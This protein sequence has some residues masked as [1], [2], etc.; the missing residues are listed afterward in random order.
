[1][2]YADPLTRLNAAL[3][4]RYRIERELGEGGMATVYLADDL[5]HERQ[6]ALKVLKPEL[7][8]IV[9][10]KRFL[11]EIKTTAN[12]QHP[13]ILPLYDSG[14]ADGFPFYVMPYVEDETLRERLDR[15]H[16]LPVDEAV[17]IAQNVAEALDYAHR[18][19]VI[20][21]DIKPGNVLMADGKAVVSDFGIALAVGASGGGRLTET[22]MTLGTPHYMSPEQAT[23]D[24]SAGAAA[25]VYA[26]GCVL[27]EMLVGDPPFTGNTP[28]AV[29][30]RIIIGETP[31]ATAERPTVPRNVDATIRRALEKIP[32]DRFVRAADLASALTD[33]TFQHG[34]PAAAHPPSG[35]SWTT[36][37]LAT[38]CLALSAALL[39]SWTRIDAPGPPERFVVPFNEG[40]EPT[41]RGGD[42]AIFPD[43]TALVYRAG[44]PGQ[45]Q[46][47]RLVDGHSTSL[48]GTEGTSFLG[49][50]PLSPDAGE[51]AFRSAEEIRVVSLSGGGSRTLMRGRGAS[52]GDEGYLYVT[53]DDGL[54]RIPAEGGE[55]EPVTRLAQGEVT[56]TFT[57]AVPG[58]IL[59]TV[60]R[61]DGADV[62]LVEL[63][64]FERTLLVPDAGRGQWL[65]AGY[66]VYTADGAL[67]AD[68]FDVGARRVAGRPVVLQTGVGVFSIS[69]EG[70]LFY[71]ETGGGPGPL[72]LVWMSRSGEPTTLSERWFGMANPNVSWTL[73]PDD[74]QVAFTRWVDGNWDVWTLA[75]STGELRR[76]TDHPAQDLSPVWSPEGSEIGFVSVRTD[77]VAAPFGFWTVPGGGGEAPRLLF[78]QQPVA[79]GTWSPDGRWLVVRTTT[80]PQGVGVA[81]RDILGI[82]PG[83]DSV[84]V[85]LAAS[86]D[87]EELEPAV[88]PDGRWLAYSSNAT[89]RRE[90]FVQPFPDAAGVRW[91]VS[92]EGGR[93]PLW[94][95]RPGE[96]FFRR[97]DNVFVS[98]RYDDASSDFTIVSR[99]PLFVVPPGFHT[100]S[101]TPYEVS[102]D[103]QRFLMARRPA[104]APEDAPPR[105]FVIDHWAQEV[106]RR[107]SR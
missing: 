23:G 14:E 27:Y 91:P 58:G 100:A 77:S 41:T 33:P 55:P 34:E 71:R 6:V 82:R 79:M 13:H 101:W 36:P 59:I 17:Q 83:I 88:S 49:H 4:G 90:V 24:A 67:T 80:G 68:A 104:E 43:G 75:T 52:W 69:D 106:E 28:Q 51:V 66:L 72:E 40:T 73:S 50:Q 65:D 70:R 8:A 45:L 96:L 76:L 54:D 89:G 29:L 10:A 5:R 42:W 78:G 95:H 102:S 107:L 85:P 30:G 1:M 53:T 39:W 105:I 35:S 62:E 32:A 31:S 86:P 57:D 81:A 12:L 87:A 47:R 21:R 92:L 7:A 94:S 48:P 20:H 60:D 18:Q 97:A 25:D 16:Q 46:L 9:G 99:E 11:A 19:G 26:L 56:H 93:M 74:E 44:P 2:A 103:D 37:L 15:E 64:S 84:P 61:G 63:G 22:G 98:I 3:E 38:L